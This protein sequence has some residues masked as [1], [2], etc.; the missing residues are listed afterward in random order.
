MD[1]K[2]HNLKK[3]PSYR[4]T[5]TITNETEVF[6]SEELR[7]VYGVY[8]STLREWAK[9]GYVKRDKKLLIEKVEEN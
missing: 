6:T 7:D 4:L 2:Q 3:E 1:I 9:R 8:N 5:S